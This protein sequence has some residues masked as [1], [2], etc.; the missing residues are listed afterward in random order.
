LAW[1][2]CICKKKLVDARTTYK[3]MTYLITNVHFLFKYQ[4]GGGTP[5][6]C[7]WHYS[8]TRVTL[9]LWYKPFVNFVAV[10]VTHTTAI[11]TIIKCECVVLNV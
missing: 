10:S 11:Y 6:H 7:H 4:G 9:A 2:E 5:D 1:F 3:S 8:F